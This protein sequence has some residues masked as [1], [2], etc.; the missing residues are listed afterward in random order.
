[1]FIRDIKFK[2]GQIH[3]IHL[4]EVHL[5]VRLGH[6]DARRIF[7]EPLKAQL[8]AT[9][10]GTVMECKL[11]KRANEDVIGVDLFL[12]LTQTSKA[13]LKLVTEMLEQLSAPLGSSI[14][15]SDAPSSV[16]TFGRAEG[17]ELSV[18][19]STTPNAEAR[20]NLA[21]L[22]RGALRNL[23]VNRGWVEKNGRTSLFFYGEN[24]L[25]METG[26]AKVLDAHP[27]YSRA[28]LRRLA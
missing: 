6:R 15:L 12:G 23:G 16:M 20:R 13:S 24:Y 28:S 18:D 21:E 17:I 1:M 2:T 27:V 14:R 22:C 11:R 10:M 25:A 5:P 4:A 7:A 3:D 26:L 8:A 19:Q 9:A